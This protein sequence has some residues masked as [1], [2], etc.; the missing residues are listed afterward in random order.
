MGNVNRYNSLFLLSIYDMHNAEWT[1][2]LLSMH[3]KYLKQLN[4]Y[5]KL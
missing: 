1:T 5:K 4:L 2:N 3:E